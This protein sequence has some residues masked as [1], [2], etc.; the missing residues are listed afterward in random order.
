MKINLINLDCKENESPKFPWSFKDQEFRVIEFTF[1]YTNNEEDRNFIDSI[2]SEGETLALLV[3]PWSANNGLRVRNV[4]I[5]KLHWIGWVFAEKLWKLYLDSEGIETSVLPMTEAKSQIDLTVTRNSKKI[6]VR[7]SFPRNW[8]NFAICHKKN[9]FDIIWPYSASYKP[10]EI[11][12][13][14]YVRTLYPYDIDNFMTELKWDWFKAY[15]CWGATWE[16]MGNTNIALNKT[17]NPD[18]FTATEKSNYRV[19]PYRN[20]LDTISIMEEI[21]NNT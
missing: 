21:K 1:S 6:E 4:W 7:S 15:L 17:F 11:M 5:L 8:I 12:K 2:I 9:E 18:G 16:M 14:Y 19:I 3:N 13:D 20:A 10:W